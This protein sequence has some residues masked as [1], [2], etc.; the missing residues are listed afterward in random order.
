MRTSFA[1]NAPALLGAG[2]QHGAWLIK[3]DRSQEALQLWQEE[4]ARLELSHYAKKAGPG[5]EIAEG[6]GADAAKT[7]KNQAAYD[8]AVADLAEKSAA[9]NARLDDFDGPRRH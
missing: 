5:A 4:L 8:L 3:Q 1:A 7:A 2:R 6:E 9:L